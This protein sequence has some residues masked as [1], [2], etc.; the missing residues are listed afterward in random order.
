MKSPINRVRR[1]HG[2]KATVEQVANLAARKP[3]KPQNGFSLTNGAG[4]CDYE[5]HIP[6]PDGSVWSTTGD[7]E[8]SERDAYEQEAGRL[9]ISL[10]QV[11]N[12]IWRDHFAA[13]DCG[14]GK[15]SARGGAR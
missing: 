6:L 12:R 1:N 9:G 11:M 3:T 5:L 15:A 4:A 2:T 7:I 14:D 10:N 13:A 8:E